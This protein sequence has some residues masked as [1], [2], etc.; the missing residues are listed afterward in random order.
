MQRFVVC[1]GRCILKGELVTSRVSQLFSDLG[2]EGLELLEA[3]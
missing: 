1:T 2:L 3:R